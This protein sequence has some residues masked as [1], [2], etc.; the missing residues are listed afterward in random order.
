MTKE[1][2]KQK[3]DSKKIEKIEQ[4]IQENR[5]TSFE[6]QREIT[7]ALSYLRMSGRFKENTQYNK[8]SFETYLHGQYN[9]RLGT[10]LENERAVIHYP[11]VAKQYGIGLVAKV[12]RKC[13]AR[14]EV[15]VFKE[16]KEAKGNAPI[17]QAKIETIIT[18]H[19]PTP[20]AKAPVIDWQGKYETEIKAHRETKRLLFEAKEQIEKLKAT[21]VELR[22]LRDMK[23]AIE[24]FMIPKSAQRVN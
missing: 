19:S 23:A 2:L 22:P 11:E 8:S 1:Q 4:E 9:I 15:A 16:I 24:P 18:K 13:G 3:Y 12:H 7:L 21:V 20:R 10:F 14:E 6:A 5:G 17:R